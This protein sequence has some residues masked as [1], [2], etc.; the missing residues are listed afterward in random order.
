M[1]ARPTLLPRFALLLLALL[2]LALLATPAA[3]LPAGPAP[4]PGTDYVEIADGAA[5]APTP[6]MIEVVEVFGYTCVHCAH[7]EPRVSAWKAGL[8]SDVRFIAVAAPFGGHWIPYARAYYAAQSLG[9][10]E[11]THDAMFRALHEEGSLPLSRPTDHEVAGFYAGHGADRQ[12]FIDAMASAEVEA[13]LE[14]ARRF[15]RHSGVEGTPTLIVNGKY[16]VV[17]GPGDALRIAEHLIA[18][19]RA[20]VASERAAGN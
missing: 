14:R 4:V 18:R 13:Q 10:A 6:G 3:K 7:F 11:R 15:L 16:R 5:F 1:T 17:G 19:E 9:L 20:L 12:R 8:P 2:P